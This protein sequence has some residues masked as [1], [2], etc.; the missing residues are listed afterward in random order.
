MP[1]TERCSWGWVFMVAFHEG[2]RRDLPVRLLAGSSRKASITLARELL[3]CRAR[4]RGIQRR[5]TGRP[6]SAMPKLRWA[7]DHHRDVRALATASPSTDCSDVRPGACAMTRRGP[8][9]LH[10]VA[11]LLRETTPAVPKVTCIAKIPFVAA[12]SPRSDRPTRSGQNSS[13]H[14]QSHPAIIVPFPITSQIRNP[15]RPSLGAPRVVHVRV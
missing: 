11:T 15:H 9:I 8:L 7:Y 13:R 4:A 1:G 2:L 10:P 3:G 6:A 14:E 12:H 5:E